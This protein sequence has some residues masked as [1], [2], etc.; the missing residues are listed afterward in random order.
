MYKKK[1]KEN[2]VVFCLFVII[3]LLDTIPSMF[4]AL[5]SVFKVIKNFS[6]VNPPKK[7]I[8]RQKFCE[9]GKF[10]LLADVPASL[11]SPLGIS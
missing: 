7:K 10:L 11:G 4:N 1:K 9:L 3:T 5:F 8:M 6:G 2:N